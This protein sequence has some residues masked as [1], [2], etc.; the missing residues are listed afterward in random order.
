M[1]GR[2]K[3]QEALARR[4]SEVLRY[5]DGKRA[6]PADFERDNIVLLV[7]GF[8]ADYLAMSS[9]AEQFADAGFTVL[10]FN[11]PCFDGIDTAAATLSEHLVSLNRLCKQRL[12]NHRLTL[13]CHSMGGLVARALIS[14]YGGAKFVRRVITLGTPH[15]GTLAGLKSLEVLVSAMEFISGVVSR[16]FPQNSRSALQLLCRDPERLVETL[17]LAQP[18]SIPVEFYSISAGKPLIEIGD[19]ELANRA[20]NDPIQR[21]MAG[22][23]NDGLVAEESSDLSQAKFSR[24]CP[25][26]IHFTDYAEYARTNH[27]N[28]ITNYAVTLQAIQFALHG[29]EWE[30]PRTA[31]QV[32]MKLE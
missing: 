22:K 23:T 20:A 31:T 9:L 3:E 8:T 7:H 15:A 30:S 12:T 1:F 29:S 21:A 6:G 17:R 25:G 2:S 18:P 19:N 27:T 13:V 28:L 11:Y 10:G 16:G 14:L 24:C 4:G 26:A 32:T 5:S